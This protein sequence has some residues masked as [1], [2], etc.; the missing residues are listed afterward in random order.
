MKLGT[1][2][3]KCDM[4][5]RAIYEWKDRKGLCLDVTGKS[6]GK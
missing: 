5:Q 2:L 4:L 6:T 3:K 1:E